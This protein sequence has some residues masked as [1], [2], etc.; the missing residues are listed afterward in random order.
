VAGEDRG[1]SVKDVADSAGGLLRKTS[2]LS[3]ALAIQAT[4]GGIKEGESG[5]RRLH[6]AQRL[7]THPLSAIY[8][9]HVDRHH[10]AFA[11]FQSATDA[12][13]PD[14]FLGRQIAFPLSHG[15]QSF[16]FASQSCSQSKH[17]RLPHSGK[18]VPGKS[19][20]DAS[21]ASFS[22]RR[23]LYHFLVVSH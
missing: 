22:S 7:R 23:H 2:F 6:L 13:G 21:S 5:S 12:Y 11:L 15:V 16:A 14:P 10:A 1:W 3:N 4:N 18:S 17:D 20:V 9:R 8:R 19:V